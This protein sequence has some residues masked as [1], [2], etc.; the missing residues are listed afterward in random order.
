MPLTLDLLIASSLGAVCLLLSLLF[1]LL[2]RR[3]KN[4]MSELELQNAE[5]GKQVKEYYRTAQNQKYFSEFIRVLPG[6][7]RTLHGNLK[8]RQIP[9]A[10]LEVADETFRPQDSVV[11]IRRKATLTEPER[12]K[13]YIVAAA[14]PGSGLE[15]G[16]T[17]TSGEG[18]LGFVAE[19]RNAMNR[20][21][22]ERSAWGPGGF[23]VDLAAPLVAK[24][25][26]LGVLALHRPGR[27]V[28]LAK[29]ILALLAQLG[30]HSLHSKTALAEMKSVAQVDPLTGIYNKRV[31]TYRLGEL[32]YEAEAL[33]L[34]LS[35]FLFD[36]DHFKNYNDTNGH[37]AGD[38][39]LRQLARLV[40]DELRNEDIFGR[41]GGE[42][43]LVILPGRESVVAE[44][45]A[46]MLRDRIE[47][48]EFPFGDR[49][50]LGK[51][52][53]SGGVAGFPAD[54]RNSSELLKSADAALYSA[55]RA[56][57]NRVLSVAEAASVTA[58]TP[59][60]RHSALGGRN[61][62]DDQGF[63]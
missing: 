51:L 32:V 48:F 61:P 13:Q 59:I 2:L 54:A 43:F 62:R 15:L 38:Q 55:K 8:P 14:S 33:D 35:V 37:V 34:P 52:T 5:L 42:E 21:D 16:S 45:V 29:E 3:S 40:R 31:L 27:P 11:L 60:D 18:E 20:S 49:Q 57:R 44:T 10:L 58:P 41:F 6:Y 7:I 47:N 53:I 24:D 1:L 22:L 4:R 46:K 39:V 9:E 56:G 50:P 28:P 36:I 26:N 63:R 25:E 30:A 17:I 23:R 19:A 12:D